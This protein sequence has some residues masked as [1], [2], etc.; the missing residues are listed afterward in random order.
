MRSEPFPVS[1]P[2]GLVNCLG[3]EERIVTVFAS[4]RWGRARSAELIEPTDLLRGAG[5][6]ASDQTATRRT[7]PPSPQHTKK[8]PRGAPLP[9][10]P[11]G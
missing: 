2:V 8:K 11:N 7:L 3:G 10:P 6:D 5:T 4:G 1:S 9:H